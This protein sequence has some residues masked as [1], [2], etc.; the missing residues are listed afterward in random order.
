MQTKT[1]FNEN[2]YWLQDAH[3]TCKTMYCN[4]DNPNVV[5]DSRGR[6]ILPSGTIWP[7]NEGVADGI[8]LRDVEIRPGELGATF[9]LLTHGHVNPYYLPYNREDIVATLP[10]TIVIVGEDSGRVGE[11]S[12]YNIIRSLDPTPV[13]PGLVPA[14]STFNCV[15][16]IHP[17][18]SMQY[19]INVGLKVSDVKIGNARHPLVVSSVTPSGAMLEFTIVAAKAFY[20]KEGE[21]IPV[22][23]KAT[24]L[25]YDT[26]P[27]P[28][29]SNTVIALKCSV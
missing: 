6:R 19:K 21:T 24:G 9:S 17:S 2:P 13:M 28:F 10:A 20:M 5:T 4:A 15:V 18:S 8:V 26:R 16:E 3:F 12:G 11:A 23:I 14:G 25:M 22:T 29:D 1:V 7:S 27:C